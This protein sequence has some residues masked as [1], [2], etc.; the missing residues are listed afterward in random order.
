M[1]CAS[2]GKENA[3]GLLFCG[4]CGSSLSQT[5]GV[6]LL[7]QIARNSEPLAK[8]AERIIAA[9]SEALVKPQERQYRQRSIIATGIIFIISVIIVLSYLL[10][11]DGILE[12]SGF[13]FIVGIIL[14]SIVTLIGDLLLTE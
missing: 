3:E 2:C 8:F 11:R 1:I 14:G 5:K 10:T 12:G 6:P 13:A 4:Y 9:L 7:E